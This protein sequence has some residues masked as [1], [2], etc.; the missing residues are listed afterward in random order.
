M[1]DT[2]NK[3]GIKSIIQKENNLILGDIHFTLSTASTLYSI[4]NKDP[5]GIAISGAALTAG[6]VK[7]VYSRHQS[8]KALENDSKLKGFIQAQKLLTQASY[9][10]HDYNDPG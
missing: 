10:K 2:L 3:N 9:L 4:I 5:L 1:D 6:T 8:K 7:M